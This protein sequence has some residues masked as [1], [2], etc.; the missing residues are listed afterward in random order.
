VSDDADAQLIRDVDRVKI[1]VD[2]EPYVDYYA[3]HK[4]INVLID[5]KDGRDDTRVVG[6][7]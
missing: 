4:Q 2:G 7:D 6:R 1:Y 3:E 5:P